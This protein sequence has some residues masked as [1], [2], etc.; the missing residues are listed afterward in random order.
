MS[1]QLVQITSVTHAHTLTTQGRQ[2]V[3]AAASAAECPWHGGVVE[4]LVDL[5]AE[6]LILIRLGL[7]HTHRHAEIADMHRHVSKYTIIAMFTV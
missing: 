4:E 7:L 5:A 3:A 2:L 1:G 6:L